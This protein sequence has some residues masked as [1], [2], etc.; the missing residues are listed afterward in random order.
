[1]INAKLNPDTR[2]ILVFLRES[3]AP[4]RTLLL[5]NPRRH[6]RFCSSVDDVERAIGSAEIVLG[7]ITFPAEILRRGERLRWIQVTGAGVDRFLA[8]ADLPDDVVLTRADV[9]FGDQ[10]AEYV[11]GHLLARTQRVIE[12]QED[13]VGHMWMPRTLRWLKGK[14]MAIAG[15]GSIGRAVAHRARG[16]RMRVTGYA[17][18]TSKLPEFE[19]IYGPQ[20]LRDFL[21]EADVLIIT[22][23]LTTETRG[24]IGTEALA[25]MKP[26]A[27]L[28]NVARGA[29]VDEQALVAS[30]QKEAIGGA[31]LD[32][33]ETEPLPPDHILW[34]LPNVT[35][36]PHHAGLNIPEQIS[37]FFL[38]NLR[39]YEDGEPLQGV[40][41][42]QRGY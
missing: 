3:D 2:E 4:Y 8:G 35:I 1:M 19:H 41:D 32:V 15:T 29:I 40:V 20:E 5:D 33:F 12:L 25:T 21:R 22:L 39:R 38:E 7:S 31:I 10:I 17:R 42:R 28:V 36:T 30:L 14:T 23:P 34:E 18:T 9:G 27:V 6:Y 16:M 26:D 13:Q 24:L 11:F 37:S